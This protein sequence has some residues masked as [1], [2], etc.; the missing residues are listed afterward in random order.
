MASVGADVVGA[1]GVTL[2]GVGF[3]GRWSCERRCS[4]G[5]LCRGRHRGVGADVVGWC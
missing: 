2:E 1:N 3:V 4:D 5:V